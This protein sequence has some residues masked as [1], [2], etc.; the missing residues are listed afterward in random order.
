[1]KNYLFSILLRE[2]RWHCSSGVSCDRILRTSLKEKS[3][4]FTEDFQVKYGNEGLEL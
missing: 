3:A 4:L 2:R 1:M